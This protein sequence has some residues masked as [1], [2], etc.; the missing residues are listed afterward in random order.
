MEWNDILMPRTVRMSSAVADSILTHLEIRHFEESEG[1]RNN[2]SMVKMQILTPLAVG[3]GLRMTI[4]V[5]GRRLVCRYR[6]GAPG[7]TPTTML[8]QGF[9]ILNPYRI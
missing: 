8:M 1:R 4:I 6:V 9:K 3:S 7:G 2:L 5:L